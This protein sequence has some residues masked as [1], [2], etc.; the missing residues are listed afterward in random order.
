MRLFLGL[1]LAAAVGVPADA[2][3]VN[4]SANLNGANQNPPIARQ[5]PAWRS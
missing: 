2:A 4:F 1:I 3:L 5:P